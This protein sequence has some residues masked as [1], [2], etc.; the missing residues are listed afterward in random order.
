MVRPSAQ[1]ARICPGAR[2]LICAKTFKT[3]ICCFAA[4]SSAC[5]PR[6]TGANHWTKLNN[7][8][9]T[10]AVHEV[11][12]HPSNG[13]IV[14]ATHGRSLWA[15]DISALRQLSV[16]HVKEKIALFKPAE[17][18][19]WQSEPARGRTNRRFAGHQPRCWRRSFGM[20]PEKGGAGHI[21]H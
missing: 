12:M 8:L 7:N 1:F 9:P 10:V 18:V 20:P 6:W 21:A 3:K 2:R 13:E 4:P 19:R 5:G 17:V 16:E 14:A 15:C 11:A